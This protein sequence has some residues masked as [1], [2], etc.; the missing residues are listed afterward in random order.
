[1]RPLL[2]CSLLATSILPLL[3]HADTV[4]LNNGDRLTGRIVLL[5]SGKLMLETD[6]AGSVTLSIKKISTME[7]DHPL[8]I[9]LDTFTTVSAK[10]LR[11][12]PEGS[13]KLVNGGEPIT[14]ALADIDQ[15]MVPKPVIKDLRWKGNISFSADYKKKENDSEDYNLDVSTELRHGLWRHAV[16]TEYDYETKNSAKKTERFDATYA[17][18]RFITEQWFWKNKAKYVHDQLEELTRQQTLGTGPGYQF[19]DN[20]LGALAVSSLINHNKY[21][22]D[23]GKKQSFNSSTVSWN[24]N[25]YF[26]GKSFEIYTKG[27]VGVPFISD[28]DYILDSEAGLRYKLNSWAALTLKAEW[29]KVASQYGDLND[30]RY[31][32][33]VGVGW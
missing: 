24:Y 27:D 2:L 13:V 26:S 3:A 22:F 33:G 28:V 17:L 16:D 5:D 6:Y 15:L 19:W 18:D 20:E 25:R 1:M 10:A 30:R 4:W 8:L 32:I 7:T 29:N 21:K 14:I 23:S 11:A 31:L 12:G 9:K